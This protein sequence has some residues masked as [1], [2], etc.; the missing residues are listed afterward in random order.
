MPAKKRA[1][2]PYPTP[3]YFQVPSD[4]L[5]DALSAPFC[6]LDPTFLGF[7]HFYHSVALTWPYRY[8]VI[9]V[10]GY[11][12]VQG[13]LFRDFAGYVDLDVALRARR[14]ALPPNGRHIE[15][16]GRVYIGQFRSGRATGTNDLFVCS[17]VP[18]PELRSMVME[19]PNHVVWYPGSEMHVSGP[20][21]E[22][23]K[24]VFRR[25]SSDAWDK[26]RERAVLDS[27]RDNLQWL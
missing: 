7:E 16:D 1:L 12:G 15:A 6:E 25:F 5:H 19:L 26:R 11:I 8:R 20:F 23:T 4:V 17:A 18:D 2:L 14:C 22:S 24:A 21:G 10:G 13:W 27:L 9:D 3:L